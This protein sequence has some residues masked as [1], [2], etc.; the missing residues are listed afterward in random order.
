M[1]YIIIVILGILTGIGIIKFTDSL[2]VANQEYQNGEAGDISE[3][4]EF[5][6]LDYEELL[7]KIEGEL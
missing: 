1:R 5:V 7:K 2:P 3:V 6:E 4:L